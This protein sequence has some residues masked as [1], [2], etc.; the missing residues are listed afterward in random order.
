MN[1]GLSK[2]DI[3]LGG[4][5]PALSHLKTTFLPD[6]RNLLLLSHTQIILSNNSYENNPFLSLQHNTQK[7]SFS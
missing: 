3:V 1:T 4:W 2:H 5:E 7:N 6:D